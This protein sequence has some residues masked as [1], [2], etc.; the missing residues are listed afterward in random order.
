MNRKPQTFSRTVN[1][2][3]TR[4]YDPRTPDNRK[5]AKWEFGDAKPYGV[6]LTNKFWDTKF[7]L[8]VVLALYVGIG[9]LIALGVTK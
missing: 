1:G 4:F 7:A 5:R 8:F 9:V 3:T 2:K 6:S